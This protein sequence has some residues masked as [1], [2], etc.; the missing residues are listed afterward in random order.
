MRKKLLCQ[1]GKEP[2]EVEE[3]KESDPEY[4]GDEDDEDLKYESEAETGSVDGVS[5]DDSDF[6]EDWEWTYVLPNE[7]L[8]PTLVAHSVNACKAIVGVE[9]SRNPEAT[10]VLDF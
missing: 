6:D 5:I 4:V 8:N 1:I 7:T 10:T 9:A 2:A 3:E